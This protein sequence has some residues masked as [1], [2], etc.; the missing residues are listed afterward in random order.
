MRLR[1][2]THFFIVTKIIVILVKENVKNQLLFESDIAITDKPNLLRNA[3]LRLIC[4]KVYLS[5]LRFF[6]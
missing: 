2:V 4:A 5:E 1:L 6:F 3:T